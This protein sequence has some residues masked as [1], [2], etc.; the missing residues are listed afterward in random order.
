M[1]QH[2]YVNVTILRG[3]KTNKQ[4]NTR[5]EKKKKKYFRIL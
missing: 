5:F 2:K 4:F 1:N 3:T